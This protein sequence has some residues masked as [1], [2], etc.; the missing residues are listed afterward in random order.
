MPHQCVKCGILHNN[1][2]DALI[3]GCSGCSSK[4]FFFVKDSD[5]EKAKT[6]ARELSSD[7]KKQM[8][9]DVYE[10]LGE[11]PEKDA[12]VILEFESI[13]IL[14]PGKYELDLVN[15]FKEKH[16]IVYKL[17]EGK[18]VIDLPETF[19]KIKAVNKKRK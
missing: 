4:V 16:P 17:E 12:P 15:L 6:R 2:S 13:N 10:I 11:D 8:E 5:L 14:E 19:N 1:D 3:K 7:Q 18:Y 9:K